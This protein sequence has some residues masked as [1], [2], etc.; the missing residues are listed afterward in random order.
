M[1]HGDEAPPSAVSAEFRTLP[2]AFGASPSVHTLDTSVQASSLSLR[3][4]S[5]ANL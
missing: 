5:G 1:N 3:D 2:V 4:W